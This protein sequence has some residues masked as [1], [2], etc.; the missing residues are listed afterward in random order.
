MRFGRKAIYYLLPALVIA[1]I[2]CANKAGKNE[3]PVDTPGN[4]SPSTLGKK[5]ADAVF[6]HPTGRANALSLVLGRL[7]IQ[8]P[9]VCAR[10]GVLMFADATEDD[11]LLNRLVKVYEPFLSGKR[12]PRMWLGHVDYKVFGIVPFELHQQTGNEEYLPLALELAD[13]EFKKTKHNG[14]SRY[15]R[16]WV[17]DMYMVGA[18]Q[19]EAYE[20]TEKEV[21]ADRAVRQVLAYCRKLQQP[22]G[23]FH[24]NLKAPFFWGRGNGWAAASMA[25]ILMA[26]PEDYPKRPELLV[27]YRKMMKGLV[28]YQGDSGMWHQLIDEPASYPETSSTGMFVFALAT[29]VREGWLP[30]TPYKEA[31][32]K[33]W[34]ALTRY[35]DAEGKVGNVCVGTVAKDSKK[36]Y[37]NRPRKTGDLHGQAAFL[38]AASAVHLLEKGE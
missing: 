23:L 36:H 27:A 11:E 29:G 6:E 7:D 28:K 18:L 25:E 16:F 2:S 9:M 37:M 17:D 33:G 13:S 24:H 4:A 14:L 30:A 12:K 26:L 20:S 3:F 38:W 21:Y 8:Y 22:N 32:K 35:I 1:C 10:Y 5:A 31:A 19:S 34:L 15:T